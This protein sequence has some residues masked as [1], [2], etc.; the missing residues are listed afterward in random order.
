MFSFKCLYYFANKVI[1]LSF[2]ANIRLE[3]YMWNNMCIYLNLNVNCV[4][5][6]KIQI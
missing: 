6:V 4:E 1:L 3:K 2:N 5:T